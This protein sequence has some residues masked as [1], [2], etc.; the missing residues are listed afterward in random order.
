MKHPLCVAAALAVLVASYVLWIAFENSP[1]RFYNLELGINWKR[2]V[3]FLGVGFIIAFVVLVAVITKMMK[4][5]LLVAAGLAALVASYVLWFAL[6]H[7]PQGRFYG[8]E[9][10]IEWGQIAGVWGSWFVVAFAVFG[11]LSWVITKA[12]RIIIKEA[13]DRDSKP[14]S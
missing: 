4:H 6:E 11:V 8:S 10:G 13:Q 7:N 5:P 14:Y 9:R 1:Q 12:A 2:I 3:T